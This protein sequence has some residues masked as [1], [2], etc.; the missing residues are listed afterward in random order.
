M[1]ISGTSKTFQD[2]ADNVFPPYVSSQLDEAN[3]MDAIW[4]VYNPDHLKSAAREKSGKGVSEDKYCLPQFFP[5]TGKTSCVWTII[6]H[7][8]S[9]SWHNKWRE[10]QPRKVQSYMQL[11]K[12]MC[13]APLLMLIWQTWSSASTKKLIPVYSYMYVA[14][15]VKAGH[16]K[17]FVFAQS[18]PTWLFWLS[19]TITIS[20]PMSYEWLLAQDHISTI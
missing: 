15:A 2:Y 8:Y 7:N 12:K 18:I 5:K 13:C 6:K 14:D 11:W 19:L 1:L 20:N 4:V 16:M 10:S 9:G 17:V 3:R